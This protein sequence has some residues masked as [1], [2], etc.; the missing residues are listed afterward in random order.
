MTDGTIQ[1]YFAGLSRRVKAAKCGERAIYLYL[2]AMATGLA[3]LLPTAATAGPPFR[4]DDPEPVDYQH[5]EFYTF[6]TGTH[7]SGDTSGVGPAWEFN[8]GLIPDGQFHIVAPLAF[9]SP[10]GGPPQFGYGDTELGFKYRFIQED[11]KGSR[12]MVGVFPLVELPT[13]DQGSG[14][15]AGHTRVY[16]PVW[17]Q[18]SFGDWT[19][20]GGGGYWINHDA[21]TGDKD[22]WFFG[23]LLQKKIT[24]KLVIGGELFHQT[25]DMIGGEDSTGFNLGAVYDFDDHNHLLVSAGRGFQNASETN[26]YSWYLG[27]QITGP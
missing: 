16:L 7:V 26:L 23:W 12:P 4:T 22:Y 3:A 6:T 11:D 21:A 8:Y 19:T 1:R 17:L 13:G 25:A 2:A 14:L 10:T 5:Y 9:D 15:G 20:Y 27:Y 18:K 24:D